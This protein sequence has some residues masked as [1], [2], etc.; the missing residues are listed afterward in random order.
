MTDRHRC[1]CELVPLYAL[2]LLDFEDRLWVEAQI[3]ECPDLAEELAEYQAAV[4]AIPYTASSVPM[5]A[6][7]KQRLFDRFSIRARSTS[8]PNYRIYQTTAGNGNN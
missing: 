4:G 6:D 5:S 3:V 1:F 7:L 8:S 2:D